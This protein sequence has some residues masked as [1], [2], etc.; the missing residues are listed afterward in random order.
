[1]IHLLVVDH[2]LKVCKR[3]L[4]ISPTLIEIFA[5][6][7]FISN[8][9]EDLCTPNPC[10]TNAQCTP[11]YD[12]TRRERPVCTCLPGYTGNSLTHC[13]R[14]ECQSDNECSDNR[15]CINYSCVDPCLGQCGV[16]AI[17]EPKRHLA[18][19]KCPAGTNGDALVSCRQARNYPVARYQKKK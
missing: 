19:C 6:F 4:E 17:C 5:H 1:M 16:G 14:G 18:V 3:K 2:L 8:S 13:V 7:H 11:G 9:I 12:N 15:A 10:G